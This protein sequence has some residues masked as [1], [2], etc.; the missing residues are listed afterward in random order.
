M[1][2]KILF[3]FIA[4]MAAFLLPAGSAR[5]ADW[6]ESA[7]V[8]WYEA[9]SADVTFTINTPEELAGLA[10]LVNDGTQTFLNKTVKLG[11]DI[12]LGGKVWTGIGIT[13][14]T[15]KGLFDGQG[16]TVGGLGAIK[17][18][19]PG[20]EYIGF[21]GI[22]N[23][24]LTLNIRN[25]NVTGNVS[26][27]PETIAG[28]DYLGY[29]VGG[30]AGW[31]QGAAATSSIENCSFKGSV[32]GYGDGYVGAI[33]GYGAMVLR[34]CSAEAYITT[35]N[36]GNDKNTTVTCL[37]GLCGNA[38]QPIENCFFSGSIKN[39]EA[40]GPVSAG[41]IAG[42]TGTGAALTNC[43]VSC[44]IDVIGGQHP[45]VNINRAGYMNNAGGIA[46]VVQWQAIVG[47]S[48]QGS[49]KIRSAAAG[50]AFV[51]AGGIAGVKDNSQDLDFEHCSSV[52]KTDSSGHAGSLVGFIPEP[53][54][55][56]MYQCEW[57]AGEGFPSDC[58]AADV[59]IPE[60]RLKLS[61]T[62]V[63]DAAELTPVALISAP[64]VR[65]LENQSYTQ[66][67]ISF[68]SAAGKTD[69]LAWSWGTADSTVASI[70]SSVRESALVRG[71]KAGATY[72][73]AST[74]GFLGENSWTAKTYAAVTKVMLTSLALDAE[75]VTLT[76][77]G[78]SKIITASLLPAEEVSY[79]VLRWDLKV[80]S[81]DAAAVDDIE[82][83]HV[84]SS[85]QLKATLLKY[86]PGAQYLL[87]AYTV[88]GS[89]LSADVVVNTA[90][91]KAPDGGS[92]S[93]GGCN[94]GGY[95]WLSLFMVLPFAAS[96]L[97]KRSAINGG[98][99]HE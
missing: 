18:G 58:Y 30:I 81:G 23:G 78:D 43:A 67:A 76:G 77:A 24:G 83:T 32:K 39:A 51:N 87:S 1:S 65:I 37:G 3:M 34:N 74:N 97:K 48:A 85:R 92:H 56:K 20:G 38:N 26:V 28:R 94:G 22:L 17:C 2:R 13:G 54:N 10:K 68:P 14:K 50:D 4:L 55:I 33:A 27:A 31:A 42:T 71:V 21:F 69:G 46:G 44:D 62:K 75:S 57:L 90:E 95:G 29:R 53:T 60:N 41:G 7:D 72:I 80:T 47:C 63:T 84:G 93:S 99:N 52:M 88:D 19:A 59:D 66:K 15:F 89:E 82:L 9:N 49:I 16:Y 96:V 6:I 11:K 45:T 36:S 70:V 64:T 86:V 12:D 98:K 5:A 8:S 35:D 61:V 79:P 73:L 40:V 25:L 91:E